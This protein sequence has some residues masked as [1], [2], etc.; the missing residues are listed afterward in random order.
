ME[1]H[2]SYFKSQKMMLRKCCTQYASKFGKLSSGHRTKKKSV[3]IPIPKKGNAKECSNYCI[4]ALISHT[5]KVMLKILQT[6]LQQ[7]V[8]HE[9]PD[10]QVGFSK[11]RGT[12]DQTDNILWIIETSRKTST[13]ALLIT[14]KPLCGSQQTVENF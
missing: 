2:W 3:F 1:Y 13:S 11:G 8:N 7:Y 4:I 10:V 5:S 12:R 9:L 6:R 14:P